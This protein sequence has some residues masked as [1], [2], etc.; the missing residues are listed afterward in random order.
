MSNQLLNWLNMKAWH[1][2]TLNRG[3]FGPLPSDFEMPSMLFLCDSL[4]SEH[5]SL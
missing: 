2:E 1:N 4:E 3:V 5:F